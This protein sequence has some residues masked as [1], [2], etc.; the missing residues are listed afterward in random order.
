GIP[1]SINLGYSSYTLTTGW[2]HNLLIGDNVGANYNSIVLSDAES[3]P[4]IAFYNTFTG[5][6]EVGFYSES[7]FNYGIVDS[8]GNVGEF[9]S[10]AVDNNGRVLW[11]YYNFTNDDL[12]FSIFNA[13]MPPAMAGN[14]RS[15]VQMP[16]AFRGWAFS[17]TSIIWLWDDNSSNE[18][19][20]LVYSATSTPFSLQKI[21]N[22]N[23][24]SW[25]QE[26]L[27]PNTSYTYYVAARNADGVVTSSAATVSTLANPPTA[28]V[29]NPVDI[30]IYG[31]VVAV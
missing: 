6:L 3:R 24:I 18:T 7:G 16:T 23:T 29:V 12:K 26:G 21:T 9:V 19:N 25:I 11:A 14:P 20:F 28:Q 27:L 8:A 2:K 1:G 10:L 30:Y 4:V 15:R 31:Q 5:N 17:S 22:E 13:T